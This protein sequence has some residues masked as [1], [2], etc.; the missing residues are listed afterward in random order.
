MKKMANHFARMVSHKMRRKLEHFLKY[1]Y[2]A[3]GSNNPSETSHDILHGLSHKVSSATCDACQFPFQVVI[4]VKR[5]VDP[6][7]HH[8]VDNCAEKFKLFMAH[9]IRVENQRQR[10]KDIYESLGSDEC[11]IIMD[12]KIKFEPVYF[13][14]KMVENFGKKV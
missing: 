4:F 6:D 14:E 8:L 9:L 13:R 2:V 3:H 7:L 11:L 1:D 12:Y 5:F 10:I